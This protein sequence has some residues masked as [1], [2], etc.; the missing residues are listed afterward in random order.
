M[1]E[2]LEDFRKRIKEQ[3][4]E[5]RKAFEGTYKDEL[6]GLLGLSKDDINKITPDTT[7][8]ETYESLMTIVKEASRINVSQAELKNRIEELGNIAIEIAKKVP[9]LAKLFL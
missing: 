6:N 1:P 8:M 9:S 5:N 4:E 3:L 7:D 2:T